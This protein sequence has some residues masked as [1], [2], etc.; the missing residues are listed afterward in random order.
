MHLALP[1][2][3]TH[4]FRSAGG[5]HIDEGALEK[6]FGA[7]SNLTL[8]VNVRCPGLAVRL[9]R[10]GESSVNGERG[11]GAS[12]REYRHRSVQ[13]SGEELTDWGRTDS[14]LI[15]NQAVS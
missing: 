6:L 12:C 9:C 3:E 4:F 8:H 13:S 14:N 15:E 10:W 5:A 2:G 1:Q 11:F 7:G